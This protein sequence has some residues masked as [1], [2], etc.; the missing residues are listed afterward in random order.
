MSVNAGLQMQ[1]LFLWNL[2]V[3][4]NFRINTVF[5]LTGKVENTYDHKSQI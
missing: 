5:L 4:F 3:Y 2:I 1:N